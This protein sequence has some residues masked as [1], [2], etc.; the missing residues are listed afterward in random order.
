MT[1]IKQAVMQASSFL[2][3]SG[4]AFPRVEAELI[5]AFLLQQERLFLYLHGEEALPER[6]EE[7]YRDH[8]RR[9]SEGEPLAYITGKKEFMGLDFRVERGVLIPRPE[10][11]HLIEGVISWFKEYHPQSKEGHYRIIDLGTGCGNIAISLAYYLPRVMV[12]GIDISKK[13]LKVAVFNAAKLGL[14]DRVK[15][16]Y[17]DYRQ[18]LSG[19]Q[20]YHAVVSNPPYIPADMLASLSPEV[21]REPRIALDGG[22]DGLDAYRTI[23]CNIRKY[24]FP[25]GLLA[26]EVGEGQAGTVLEMGRMAGFVRKNDIIK[27]YAG[28]ERVVM[29]A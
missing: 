21:Q 15:F 19:E 8:V 28:I 4:L 16:L 17:G 12:S 14:R 29:L 7:E 25:C 5:L 10:T 18:G 23:F 3:K 24:L 13:A 9:R 11:E 2:S 6:L 22:A 20:K 1:V 26:L 27:D